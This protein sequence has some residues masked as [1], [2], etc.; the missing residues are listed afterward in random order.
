MATPPL[1][2]ALFLLAQLHLPGGHTA[3]APKP[4]AAPAVQPQAASDAFDY[5]ILV[6]SWAPNSSAGHGSFRLQGLWPRVTRGQ[7]P[8]ACGQTKPVSK[9]VLKMM[10]HYIQDAALVQGEWA[11]HGTCSG[12][13]PADYFNRVIEA[14]VAV[15]IPVQLTSIDEP[16]AESPEQIE[17]E[18]A[19]A[20]PSFPARAFRTS[21]PRGALAE[22]RVC[23]DGNLKPEE[24]P[25]TADECRGPTLRI[26]P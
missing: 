14:F 22:V 13:T 23:F 10:R 3:S 18:F 24:C 17:A 7:T 12:L 9:A 8:E 5:Y 21:C 19:G 26:L 4:V 16:V 6:L 1:T 15:Q 2:A 20:N 11:A 25:A